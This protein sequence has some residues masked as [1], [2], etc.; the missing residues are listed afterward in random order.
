[1]TELVAR[2]P[3]SRGQFRALRALVA[4]AG[5]A[6]VFG[7][8]AGVSGVRAGSEFGSAP[9]RTKIGGSAGQQFLRMHVNTEVSRRLTGAISRTALRGLFFRAHQLAVRRRHIDE[10]FAP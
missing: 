8:G 6:L 4:A 3:R 9:G 7:G 2:L 10:R 1:M 5:L